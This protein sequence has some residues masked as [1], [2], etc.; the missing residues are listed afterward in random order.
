MSKI[1][2]FVGGS[3]FTLLLA[4]GPV[5]AFPTA[6]QVSGETSQPIGHLRFCEQ[7]AAECR[8]L[9]RPNQVVRLTDAAWED[10]KAVNLAVN[11]AIVPATDMQLYGVAEVWDYPQIA[12]DCE[13]YV[14]EKRRALVKSGWPASALLITV[15]RDEI[16][17][18]HAVLTVRTD[19]G[20][21]VLDN[22][23]DE[24]LIWSQTP[25]QYL[26]RQSTVNAA[27][28]DAIADGR[29]VVVSSVGGR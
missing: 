24:I 6:M 23:R 15:V 29:D 20:D 4:A 10:L 25:Y 12:G 3:L 9:E 18:G 26:K 14:L 21:L 13:D 16:G 19:R 7:H 27:R 5:Q 2:R 28:W 1:A 17:D 22:K 8:R 11:A